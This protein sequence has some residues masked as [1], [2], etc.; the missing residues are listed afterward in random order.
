MEKAKGGAQPGVGRRGEMVSDRPTPL[1]ELRISRDQSSQWQKMTAVPEADFER[2][3]AAEE[4]PSA[5]GRKSRR[6]GRGEAMTQGARTDLQP[7]G[8]LRKVSQDDA[9][10]RL[11]V[12]RRSVTSAAAVRENGTP[13]LVAAVERGE[14]AVSVAER[15]A[16]LPDRRA[17]G[18][19]VCLTRATLKGTT[20]P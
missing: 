16:R 5:L 20:E 1:S 19:T 6:H 7:S 17:R 3:L 11:G 18:S 10:D 15:V 2:A 4:R 14:I 12:S 9:A 8:N 13:D